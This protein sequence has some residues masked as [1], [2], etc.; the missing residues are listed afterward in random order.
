M[1]TSEY[2][3]ACQIMSSSEQQWQDAFSVIENSES[4]KIE[5][6]LWSVHGLLGDLVLTTKVEQDE[7]TKFYQAPV[8]VLFLC[9]LLELRAETIYLMARNF[10]LGKPFVYRERADISFFAIE[11]AAEDEC[12]SWLAQFFDS[13]KE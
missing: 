13:I 2:L 6:Q 8:D 10:A 1:S 3:S 11:A 5:E 12:R 4:V 9:Q 7:Q